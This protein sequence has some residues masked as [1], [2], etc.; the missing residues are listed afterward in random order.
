MSTIVTQAQS[1]TSP[2]PLVAFKNSATARRVRA[3]R[4]GARAAMR[5]T[6]ITTMRAQTLRMRSARPLA[7][8]AAATS[9]DP[10]P[11]HRA[12]R[13]EV[14][15]PWLSSASATSARWHGLPSPLSHPEVADPMQNESGG[16]PAHRRKGSC[17]QP[18]SLSIGN[19]ALE[20]RAPSC[21]P[22]HHAS[23]GAW[24]WRHRRA[25]QR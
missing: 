19:N 2:L 12:T 25:K 14:L 24:S 15:L 18:V 3:G 11:V 16:L 13:L 23:H 7:S 1:R 6:L 21:D 17:R 5:P 22:G 10:P 8:T 9:T 20:R 4:Y